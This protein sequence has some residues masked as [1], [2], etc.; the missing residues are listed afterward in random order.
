MIMPQ[1]PFFLE[2]FYP[3]FFRHNIGDHLARAGFTCLDGHFVRLTPGI[4]NI[5]VQQLG[6]NDMFS[7]PYVGFVADEEAQETQAFR[8]FIDDLFSLKKR[9]SPE[10]R[11]YALQLIYDDSARQRFLQ[12]TEEELA[13]APLTDEEKQALRQAAEKLQAQ[14]EAFKPGKVVDDGDHF[15]L[16]PQTVT[17]I[18]PQTWFK[19]TW[20]FIERFRSNFGLYLGEALLYSRVTILGSVDSNPAIT[21]QQEAFLRRDENRWVERTK[22]TNADDLRRVLDWGIEHDVRFGLGD[23]VTEMILTSQP[24]EAIMDAI[25]A[26]FGPDQLEPM[27]R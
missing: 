9:A 8:N 12:H 2:K 18:A 26:K 4:G 23:G 11:W 6:A 20:P 15:L 3:Q 13:A 19:A 22:V 17:K 16:F 27:T 1:V 21:E 10:L 7:Y 14:V 25:R 24:E 5:V